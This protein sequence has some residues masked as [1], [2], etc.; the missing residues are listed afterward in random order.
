MLMDNDPRNAMRALRGCSGRGALPASQR[1]TRT[2][3]GRVT[4]RLKAVGMRLRYLFTKAQ[5]NSLPHLTIAKT[6][7]SFGAPPTSGD[8]CGGAAR[9]HFLIE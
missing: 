4:L 6:K 8:M 7:H 1:C 5:A 2:L 9:L 3:L